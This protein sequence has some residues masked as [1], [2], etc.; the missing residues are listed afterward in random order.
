LLNVFISF[1]QYIENN[2]KYLHFSLTILAG[3]LAAL[4]KVTTLMPIIIFLFIIIIW[5]WYQEKGYTFNVKLN[6]K[7][8]FYGLTVFLIPVIAIKVWTDFADH[9]KSLNEYA[10][11]FTSSTNL[12]SWNF[13]TM[14]Q[15]TSFDTWKNI[16][17][18]SQVSNSIYYFSII[19]LS[20][21][22]VYSKFKYYKPIL[23]CLFLYISAPL[24]FT[25]LHFIHDYYTFS[26]SIF[27][28]GAVGFISLSLME[29]NFAGFKI[30]GVLF[31]IAV[32]YFF[33]GRY[34]E[35]YYKVQT[36]HPNYVINTCNLVKQNTNPDDVIMVYGNDWGSE[37]AY[38]SE[39][40]TI[41]LRN[42]FKSVKDTAFVRLMDQ[43]KDYNI[44]TLVFVSYTGL[45]DNGFANELISFMGMKPLLQ[46]E[47]FFVFQKDKKM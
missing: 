47:P 24:I 37:Y 10:Y 1:L 41:A 17:Q 25:N 6:L 12:G 45:F 2:K 16:F 30:S 46:Q 27:L 31:S 44:N 26:N 9:L 21:W 14:E 20:L 33:V 22:A 40:K 28:C 4:V 13:G 35:G 18:M 34:K 3:V 11:S 29:N 32:L 38:Y 19:G 5:Q 8:I 7:Y 15:K 43:N 39:R 42:T 36:S 23:A